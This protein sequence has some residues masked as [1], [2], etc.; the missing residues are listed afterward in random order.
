MW[1]IKESLEARVKDFYSSSDKILGG[2]MGKYKGLT[3]RNQVLR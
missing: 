2:V 3:L 1:R